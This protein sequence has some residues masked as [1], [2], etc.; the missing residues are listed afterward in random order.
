MKGKMFDGGAA[1]GLEVFSKM[2]GR[3]V[4]TIPD[5]EKAKFEAAVKIMVDNWVKKRTAQG[6]P[7]ADYIS[8]LKERNAYWTAKKSK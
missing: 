8:Y 1:K 2:K 5:G 4:I 6:Y 3:E 7:A